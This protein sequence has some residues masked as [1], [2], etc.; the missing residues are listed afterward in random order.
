MTVGL[1]ISVHRA[2]GILTDFTE[3]HKSLGINSTIAI[4]KSYAASCTPPR[5][6]RSVARKNSSQ[7]SSS[8]QSLRFEI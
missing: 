8:A 7:S 2:A 1:R 4:H 3:E 5:K 6:Q